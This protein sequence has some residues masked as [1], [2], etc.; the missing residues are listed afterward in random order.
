MLHSLFHV[1]IGKFSLKSHPQL[2]TQGSPSPANS[3][4]RTNPFLGSK[5]T[6]VSP[7]QMSLT[8]KRSA[9]KQSPR[10][11]NPAG[12]SHRSQ[13]RPS[14]TARSCPWCWPKSPCGCQ[15]QW[16]GSRVLR[17]PRGKLEEREVAETFGN[18]KKRSSAKQCHD[19]RKKRP[20]F[21]FILTD[22]RISTSDLRPTQISTSEIFV[23]VWGK[24]G[25]HSLFFFYPW[26]G[27]PGGSVRQ[28]HISKFCSQ[29]VSTS[30]KFR[31]EQRKL[32]PW[33]EPA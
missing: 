29:F 3:L 13:P 12:H 17:D 26:G 18:S 23:H 24:D 6:V 7:A 30:K 11:R 16:E 1:S 8:P 10:M 19:C 15:T 27:V 14:L 31:S 4:M 28:T 2:P 32:C 5:P 33:K 9:C 20:S 22:L 25:H 21:P